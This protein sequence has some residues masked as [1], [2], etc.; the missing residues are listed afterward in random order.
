MIYQI[1]SVCRNGRAV[2]SRPRI[3]IVGDW[4]ADLGFVSGVLIQALPEQGGF[5]FNLCNEN[6]NYR[7]LF[8]LTKELGGTLIRAYVSGERTRAGI[9]LVTTGKHVLK[10]GLKVGDALIA[11]CD[12]GCIRVRKVCG[13][14]QLFHVARV[15]NDRTGLVIPNIF[16]LGGWLNDFGFE[17]DTLVTM[18]A[19]PGKIIFKAHNNSIIYRDLVKYARENGM[20][21]LQVAV[22]AGIPLINVTCSAIQK[23]GFEVGDI[24]AAEYDYGVIKLQKPDPRKFGF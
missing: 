16:L 24:L 1:L 22:K 19:K 9:A 5:V 4:L 13:N 20:H 10:G 18:A 2:S 6:V 21:L 3:Q 14:V 8:Q 11:Q 17:P 7:E 23:S 12:Y 15:K